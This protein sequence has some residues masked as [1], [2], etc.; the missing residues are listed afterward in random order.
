M[1]T[2][3]GES[4]SR[5][6]LDEAALRLRRAVEAR[7]P[8]APVRDILP[9]NDVEA[10]YRVQDIN[11]E[12]RLAGGARL[13]GRKIGLT[14][15]AVQRQLGV[16]RPDYG[17]LFADMAVPDD[18]E[19]EASS[20][21]QPRAEAEIAFVLGRDLTQAQLTI[22]DLMRAVDYAVAAI[23][24]VDSRIAR[25]DIGIV[26]TI[27]DNAS[28]GCFVLGTLPRRLDQ[29]DLAAC[30]MELLRNGSI[31]AVGSGA[32]CL[33]NP[34]AAA[35]WL[36][37]TMVAYGRPLL[38]GDIVLSGALGPMVPLNRGDLIEAA[39]AGLGTTRVRYRPAEEI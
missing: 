3:A 15:A 26:D 19:I 6:Q 7:T 38:A 12:Q 4:A 9:A 1:H 16:D 25:W 36:A 14:S 18:G 37:T 10:A 2:P 32:A 27:A 20:L 17:M 29:L 33:G 22:A 5:R 11:T 8:C 30:G 24:I 31:A 23:E 21:L 35:L 13:V 39:L 28:S 34:L